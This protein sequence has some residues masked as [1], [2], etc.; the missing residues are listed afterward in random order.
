MEHVRKTFF[1]PLAT[2][3]AQIRELLQSLPVGSAHPYSPQ[4]LLLCRTDNGIDEI[5][6]S[7]YPEDYFYNAVD[8]GEMGEVLL[9]RMAGFNL[10]VFGD[11][12]IQQ[13]P[14]ATFKVP[15]E[16]GQITILAVSERTPTYYDF[17]FADAQYNTCCWAARDTFPGI[18]HS[19]DI[20]NGQDFLAH[21]K[22]DANKLTD[23][24]ICVFISGYQSTQITRFLGTHPALLVANHVDK[25]ARICMPLHVSRI[26]RYFP[27]P[28]HRPGAP[29][30]SYHWRCDYLLSIGD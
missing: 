18:A 6:I 19:G 20:L 17:C 16:P 7:S 13:A 29:R 3:K 15:V 8:L 5:D 22:I 2:S 28:V 9:R 23:K 1:N 21:V 12:Q 10:N 4:H 26:D 14:A 11:F 25:V 24:E 27:G 30:R